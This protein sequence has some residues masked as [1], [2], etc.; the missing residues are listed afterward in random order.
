MEINVKSDITALENAAFFSASK[1]RG[2]VSP[3]TDTKATDE[4]YQDLLNFSKNWR[5]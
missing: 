4:N 5:R 2:L 1:N 3:F